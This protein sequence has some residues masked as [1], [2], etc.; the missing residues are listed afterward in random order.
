[1]TKG[2]SLQRKA[3]FQFL[4]RNKRKAI[5]SEIHPISYGTECHST[6]IPAVESQFRKISNSSTNAIVSFSNPDHNALL[7]DRILAEKRKMGILLQRLL[8]PDPLDDRKTAL[9]S[10]ASGMLSVAFVPKDGRM[11][12]LMQG[13][14]GWVVTSGLFVF[15]AIAFC[16]LASG[17]GGNINTLFQEVLNNLISVESSSSS[18]T[19]TFSAFGIPGKCILS[20]AA[21]GMSLLSVVFYFITTFCFVVLNQWLSASDDWS[22]H[23][24]V[25]IYFWFDICMKFFLLSMDTFV[26][27]LLLYIWDSFYVWENS[28]SIGTEESSQASDSIDGTSSESKKLF[29]PNLVRLRENLELSGLITAIALSVFLLAC[30]LFM[31]RKMV[32]WCRDFVPLQVLHYPNSVVLGQYWFDIKATCLEIWRKNAKAQMLE[33]KRKLFENIE[34]SDSKECL[35]LADP[36]FFDDIDFNTLP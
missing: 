24:I 2:N 11:L 16:T 17:G 8:I 25:P 28:L 14:E 23:K 34:L 27:T 3:A 9:K 26:L 20:L 33:Y 22:I 15:V 18:S 29:D 5:D 31:S 7:E 1:M 10:L 13:A 4:G 30:V 19:V 6:E 12:Q 36:C 21:R 32:L 35:L